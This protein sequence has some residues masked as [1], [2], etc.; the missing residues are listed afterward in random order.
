MLNCN[1]VLIEKLGFDLSKNSY[2]FNETLRILIRTSVP[3]L[4]LIIVSLCTAPD[5]KRRLDRFFA[6]T[7]T[8]VL[9]DHDADAREV[10]LS[11]E[12]PRRFDHAKLF[13]NSNWEFEKWDKVDTVGFLLCV[14]GCAAIIA[15]LKIVV[16]IGA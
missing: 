15:L 7:H 10:A 3:F 6:R 5:D 9:S 4:I 12:D 11:E 1:L 14:A 13:P 8:P 2:A 16:S